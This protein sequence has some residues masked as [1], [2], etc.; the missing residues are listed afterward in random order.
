MRR[1]LTSLPLKEEGYIVNRQC[2]FDLIRIR[3][4]WQLDRLPSKCECGSTFSIDHALSCKKGGFVSL[5]HNQV[6]N[7][8]ASLLNEVCHDVCVEPQLLQLTGENLNEKMAIRS[9]EARVDI[10]ARSFWVTGQMVFFDVR[11]FNPIAKRYVHMDTSKAYQLNEKEKKKNYNERI[12]EV[13]HGSFTPIVMSAYGGIG[14]EGNKFHNHL[15]E[16]L[17]KKKNEQLSVMTS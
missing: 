5:R 12:L 9:D 13:E 4:G 3:Y 6:R 2:F 14:K 1:V 7:L 11:V 16:L 17:A 10:A 15:A 8:T